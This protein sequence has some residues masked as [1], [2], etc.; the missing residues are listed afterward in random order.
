VMR[1][2]PENT[3]IGFTLDVV[4][5]HECRSVYV[6]ERPNGLVKVD[7]KTIAPV[8]RH[9]ERRGPGAGSVAKACDYTSQM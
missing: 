9:R 8:W 3:R 4:F 6:E 7:E 2:G 5:T 1:E